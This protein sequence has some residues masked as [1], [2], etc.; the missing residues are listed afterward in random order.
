[1]EV[2]FCNEIGLVRPRS[3][4]QKFG[5]RR[6]VAAFSK[7]LTSQRTPNS[8]ARFTDHDKHTRLGR[9]GT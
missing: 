6:L 3:G 8:V 2:I 5:V 7:A 9:I 4:Q 1:M